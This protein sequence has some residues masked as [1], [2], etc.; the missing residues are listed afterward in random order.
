[1]RTVVGWPDPVPRGRERRRGVTAREMQERLFGPSAMSPRP[2]SDTAMMELLGALR[3]SPAL[4]GFRLW[5]V[6][7]RVEPGRHTSDID[8]V[9]SGVA[10]TI[11]DYPR[12]EDALRHC[13]EFGLYGTEVSCVIDP[14]FRVSGPTLAVTP[15]APDAA[16]S[17]VKLLSPRLAALAVRG[18][19]LRWRRVGEFSIEFLRRAADTDYY[20]KLPQQDWC[21]QRW[22][23]LRPPVELTGS[24]IR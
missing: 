12:V 2:V 16:V 5:L 17:T 13:R 7:S 10:G 23:Y 6:G 9:L 20:D 14:C 24:P 8:L 22:R 3:Q 18:A 4:L 21:G 15:L 19:F 11:P 1:M